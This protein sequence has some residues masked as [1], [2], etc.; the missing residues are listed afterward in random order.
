MVS[1]EAQP[2]EEP[3]PINHHISD[4]KTA[5]PGNEVGRS[6]FGGFAGLFHT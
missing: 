1:M 4:M 6:Y 2:R 5:H 3:I